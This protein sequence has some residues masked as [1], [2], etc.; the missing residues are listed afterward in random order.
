MAQE[1]ERIDQ[2]R[3][4]DEVDEKWEDVGHD[5]YLRRLSWEFSEYLP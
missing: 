2:N 4:G 5:V 1:V 3:D